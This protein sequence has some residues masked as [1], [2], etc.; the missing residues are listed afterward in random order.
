MYN[1]YVYICIGTYTHIL[2]VTKNNS[3]HPISPYIHFLG[4]ETESQ[5]K[6]KKPATFPW[7]GKDAGGMRDPVGN[8][9]CM[10]YHDEFLFL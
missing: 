8:T 6:G 10:V 3:P 9:Q 7:P 4:N 1:I 5:S 2:I